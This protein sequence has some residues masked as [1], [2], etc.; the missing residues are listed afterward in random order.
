[1]MVRLV[2]LIRISGRPRTLFQAAA[3]AEKLHVVFSE[4]G[5]KLSSP[6][7]WCGPEKPCVKCGF[8][9]AATRHYFNGLQARSRRMLRDTAVNFIFF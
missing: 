9:N 3:V 2:I 4:L 7:C 8:R 6:E 1:M 5:E